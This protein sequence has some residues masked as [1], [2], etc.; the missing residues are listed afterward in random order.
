MVRTLFLDVTR[1]ASAADVLGALVDLGV[2]PSPILHALGSL[3]LPAE[4]RV[5]SEAQG[6]LV[7]AHP[8]EAPV[9]VRPREV[10]ASLSRSEL[11]PAAALVAGDALER[12]VAATAVAEEGACVV[13]H[14][15]DAGTLLAVCGA[16]MAATSLGA[17]RV[18]VSRVPVEA[19]PA[20]PLVDLLAAVADALDFGAPSPVSEDAAALLRAL[21]TDDAAWGAAEPAWRGVVARGRSRGAAA[22]LGEA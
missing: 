13:R 15:M 10:R 21:V 9:H 2:A 20:P 8:G 12:L 1:G 19:D 7:V 6:T 16:A 22:A 4:L 18:L 11:P 14:Q 5:E 3:E 17:E